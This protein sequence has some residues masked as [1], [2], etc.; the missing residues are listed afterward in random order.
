MCEAETQMPSKREERRY[1]QNGWDGS[2]MGWRSP[3]K[4]FRQLENAFSSGGRVSE[5]GCMIWVE[6]R[7]L[8][9]NCAFDNSF[10]FIFVNF[11]LLCFFS[12]IVVIGPFRTC[13]NLWFGTT[14]FNWISKVLSMFLERINGMSI[15]YERIEIVMKTAPASVPTCLVGIFHIFHVSQ[16]LSALKQEWHQMWKIVKAVAGFMNCE[17][18]A[19]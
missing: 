15:G 11:L 19:R 16:P 8:P 2:Q 3:I 6:A 5:Q 9:L 18:F 14:I 10:L 13:W 17:N 1:Q 7:S 4:F 12:D